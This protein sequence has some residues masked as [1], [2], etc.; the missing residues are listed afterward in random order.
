MIVLSIKV[1]G[2]SVRQGKFVQLGN[3]I[4]HAFI[5]SSGFIRVVSV[6]SRTVPVSFNGFGV[7]GDF[8][9]ESFGDS[10]KEVPGHPEVVSAGNSFAC[11]DLE[12]P[13]SWHDFAVCSVNLDSSCKAGAVV[14]FRNFSAVVESGAD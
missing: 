5:L 6:A 10:V 3:Y 7:K 2:V 1:N 13:L 4:L 12:L 9:T 11:S 14:G 8:D